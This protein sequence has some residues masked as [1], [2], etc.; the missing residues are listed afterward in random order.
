MG[1]STSP[2]RADHSPLRLEPPDPCLRIHSVTI[3]VRDLDRSLRF[4]VDQLGF[5]LAFERLHST[6]TVLGLFKE[7]DS[8]PAE[9]QLCTG[10]TLALY[11]D[12][13][14]E[15][16]SETGEELGE[17]RLIGALQ[18]HSELPAQALIEAIVQAV[19]RFSPH[20]QYDDITLIVGK[21]Q[22]SE[23][24]R[25]SVFEVRGSYPA[26]PLPPSVRAP[27]ALSASLCL[28]AVH[29]SGSKRPHAHGGGCGPEL[30]I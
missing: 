17:H 23:Q 20:E 11:T 1:N 28:I 2:L 16:F 30:F 8:S 13:I 27:R 21:C 14:T 9:C 19:R 26:T 24:A 18:S 10:D 29:A 4:Y 15:S 25:T 7:W 22:A 12:G 5:S 6:C 3:F